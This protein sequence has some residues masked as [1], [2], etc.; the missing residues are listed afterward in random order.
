[1]IS[2]AE[3]RTLLSQHPPFLDSTL[4][5]NVRVISVPRF[6]PTSVEQANEWSRKYW[7]S[8]FRNT[9]PFGPHP[10]IVKRAQAEILPSTGKWMALAELAAG[11]ACESGIGEEFGCAIVERRGGREEIVAVAGDGRWRGLTEVSAGT[12]ECSPGNVMAHAVMRAIGMVAQK[13]SR[14]D[15]PPLQDARSAVSN[16]SSQGAHAEPNLLGEGN[17]FV[18]RPLTHIEKR[19]FD[20]N[21]IAAHG[22]LCVDLEIYISHEPCVM[23]SMA[24]LHS[25]FGRC[26]F[27]RR[28]PLTGAMTADADIEET[29]GEL[30]STGAQTTLGYGLFWRPELNW[31]FLAWQ[32]EQDAA[33]SQDTNLSNE[34][35]QV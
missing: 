6:A 21:D 31:K 2:T 16:G 23:C 27:G 9:N 24:I 25:R 35:V 3:L 32:W 8:V 29:S 7:P 1:M 13:R 12:H 34:S 28:M 33:R 30:S 4:E 19:F 10:A 14:L 11:E 5:P 20:L 26:V 22:Y 17:I 15:D 18:D